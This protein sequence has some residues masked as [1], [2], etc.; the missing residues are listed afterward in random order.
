MG[1][2]QP[3]LIVEDDGLIRMDLADTLNE[4]GFEVIEAANADQALV[5]LEAIPA[6]RALLTDVDMPGTM[7]GIKLANIAAVQWPDCKI[8]VISGRYLP[9]EGN[10]P[11]GARFLSK[12]IA[13]KQLRVTLLDLGLFP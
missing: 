11:R 3:I 13:E 8:I 5:A 7:N 9:E 1:Q 12:P 6:V 4:N 10:L 2:K